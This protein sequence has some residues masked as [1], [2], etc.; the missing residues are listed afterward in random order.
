M[1]QNNALTF[2]GTNDYV[3]LP[4]EP[5]YTGSN[6]TAFTE[7]A[8]IYSGNTADGN[9]HGIMGSQ[10]TSTFD[11]GPS[12]YIYNAT[13]IQFGF[14]DGSTWH[15]HT[16]EDVIEQNTWVHIAVT[17]DGT[18]Y[19]LYINGILEFTTTTDAG[20]YP[21]R[22]ITY[23][24]K[25]DA[26]FSGKI[27]EVRIWDDAR[28]ET[29][30]RQNMY[31]ELSDPT[32][33][34]NLVAYYKFNAT[35][36][37]TLTDS[38][39]SHTGTLTN[40]TGSEWTAT[41]NIFGSK[42]CLDFDGSDDYV[43]LSS[44]ALYNSGNNITSFTEEAWIYSANTA[45][46]DYHGIMGSQPTS[47]FDRGPSIYVYDAT[48]MQFGFSD[49]SVWH[50]HTVNNVIEPNTWAHIAVTYDGTNYSFYVNGILKFT[51]TIDAGNY[52]TRGITY[53]GKVNT[54]FSGKIDEVRI[55]NIARTATQI[56][57]NMTR[58]LEGNESGLV[59]YYGLNEAGGTTVYDA[60]SSSN[61]GI[62]TNMDENSDWADS[63]SF[64]TWLGVTSSDWS[65]AS[66]W[67]NGV[68]TSN[69]NVGI[70][71]L[72]GNNEATISGAPEVN[73][74]LIS[75]TS[76]PTLSSGITVNGS[77]LLEKN[78]DLSGQ[79]ITLGSSAT[80]VE[81][82]GVFSGTSGSITTT[83][84]LSN[85]DEDV[86]GLG[87]TI[88]SSANMGSTSI[89]RTHAQASGN[90][91]S[92]ILRRYAISPS[93][94][95]GLDATL[96]F[97]Y[98]D[99]ELNSL[100]EANFQLLKST[101]GTTWSE[102]GGIV[103]QADNTITLSG[104]NSFSNWAVNAY[105]QPTNNTA[106]DFD[107]TDDY[108]S[109][110]Y[111]TQLDSWTV[112]CWVKGDNAP[113][114]G[115][116]R[117]IFRG[118]N[119]Q[120]NWNHDDVNY[121]G[122][123]ALED[124]PDGYASGWCSASFGTLEADIWYH[125]VATY[126]GDNLKAYKNGILI[127]D[128]GWP[129]GYATSTSQQLILGS[130]GAD[131]YFQGEIDE[132]RIWNDVRS[133]TEIRENMCLTLDGD[134]DGLV[135]YYRLNEASG[136][137][138]YDA[139]GNG[140]N[141]T[142]TGSAGWA[143]SEAFTTWLG[144]TSSDYLTASNWTDGI[145]TS[146]DNV[147]IYKW[148]GNNEVTVSGSPTVNHLIVSST[149]S[150]ILSSGLT[151]N[152]NLL[153]ESNLDLNGQ[154]IDLG[155]TGHLLEGSGNIYGTS[156][157][158]ATTRDLSNIDEN[159]AGLGAEITTTADMGSTTVTRY[160]SAATNPSGISRKYAI[161]PTNNEGLD[162]TLVFHYLD[163]ELNGQTEADLKLY[164]SSDDSSWE[165]QEGSTVNTGDNTVT[166]SGIG[167]FSY[168]TASSSYGNFTWDGSESSNWGTGTNWDGNTVPTST[169][170]VTIPAGLGNY[171]TFSSAVSCNN[172]TIESN[173]LG[174][175]SL[176]GQSNLTV[177]GTATVQRYMSGATW[178][179]TSV[180]VSGES[181]QDMVNNNSFSTNDT[182][183]GF[184]IYNEA[185]DTWITYTTGTVAAA[186]NLSPG[187]GYETNIQSDGVLNFEGG[188]NTSQ[189]DVSITR[190]GNGWN[191]LGNPY[192]SALYANDLAD[193]S[194]NFIDINAGQMDASYVALYF[195]DPSTSQ[196]EIINNSNDTTYI[197]VGQAFF[198]KSKDGGGTASF[199]TAMQVHQPTATFKSNTVNA[200]IT[201]KANNGEQT[202][203]TKFRFIEGATLDLDPGYDAGLF[204]GTKDEFVLS[205]CL[206]QDNGVA[207]ALQC[208]PSDDFE[209][210][211][212]PIE[213]NS[214][215][216]TVEFSVETSNLPS[217]I[218]VY[219]E[220]KQDNSFNL[221]SGEQIYT[222]EVN[223]GENSGRFY[224]HTSQPL[225]QL[226]ELAEGEYKI[227]PQAQSSSLLIRGEILEGM[228]L[229]IIDL[230]G[231]TVFETTVSSSTVNTPSLSNG[232]YIVKLSNGQTTYNQKINWGK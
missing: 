216:N 22:G 37:T 232:I 161:S 160:H 225:D 83:R 184:G 187:M 191:L 78:M 32:S 205:S 196:Y 142:I 211:I 167:T 105:N 30:I 219:L 45:D 27:D 46:G 113:T 183:Y 143:D 229:S 21:T 35:S 164:K 51:T 14:S 26:Y 87:A 93:T 116:S 173:A 131:Q 62:L 151:V 181:V 156:G 165:R 172:L 11:R 57:E 110:N 34:T 63:E 24:G 74:L 43:N 134:E 133:A 58:T 104:I 89:T 185:T 86:A 171:P 29:E 140:Y 163:G 8:W 179:L 12:V 153:L 2:D 230:T 192:P 125:L 18:N 64:T 59:A 136:T 212:V 96:E 121:R 144:T 119:F 207:F 166:L 81:D 127:T 25:V 77:L 148:E 92:S 85:I 7:E 73:N 155:S 101:D 186:G 102:Q 126:D 139:T 200:N 33:E 132:V 4:S 130:A 50:A 145:P 20:N 221:L 188:F 195:W 158:I 67:S 38:K 202:K 40:M 203:T 227:I 189:V 54:Y 66:N 72:N 215:T 122:S 31:Q 94:N 169:Y 208:L 118:A 107:G 112:E 91:S 124:G 138:A 70:Y 152:G 15:A 98:L 39:G 42:K 176:T 168:W 76:T 226:S 108:V 201:L 19:S 48:N 9:Y 220:D 16:V 44:E 49:G 223:I 135:A 129:D 141:G 149:S 199:T 55:W 214:V 100:N 6:I 162:A 174:T 88:T 17:Y 60:T 1:A 106:L 109:T 84:S 154:T 111:T 177:N 115:F 90:I 228:R 157:S 128:N 80:L 231:R 117:V 197:P 103:S 47:T 213:L 61:T 193:A 217:N 194:N 95:T 75:S 123:I 150:P 224:L 10:P 159:V 3:N 71:N 5:L 210:V 222:A 198:V 53:I 99:S 120:I 41:S 65:T 52:P 190:L 114:S 97:H 175:G 23:I 209:S 218:K 13:D 28:T 204:N 146:S 147:G 36:G 206:M 170:N 69:S 180:P 82:D 56:R 178:H 68:P 79:T 182:Q 137:T